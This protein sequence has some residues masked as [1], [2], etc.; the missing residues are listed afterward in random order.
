MCGQE[1]KMEVMN[2]YEVVM[3]K[4]TQMLRKARKTNIVKVEMSQRLSRTF[5]T[6]SK[7]L[8]VGVDGAW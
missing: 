7:T 6:L 8:A 1:D 5:A 4:E 2:V 3:N